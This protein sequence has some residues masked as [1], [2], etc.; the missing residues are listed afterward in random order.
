MP[1]D[2]EARLFADGLLEM[3]AAGVRPT[4]RWHAALARATLHLIRAGEDGDDLRVPIAAAL[5]QL[6]G[7][8]LDDETLT[9]AIA[10]MLPVEVAELA[11]LAA[12]ME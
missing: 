9:R 4:R 5:L 6:Y 10:I 7:E 8:E 3:T 1:D 2:V 11:R 12:P